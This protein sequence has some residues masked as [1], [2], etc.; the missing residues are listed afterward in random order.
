MMDV[1]D[2]KWSPDSILYII[3][4]TEKIYIYNYLKN[5]KNYQI[6]ILFWF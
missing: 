1:K 5:I 6:K 4:N 3:N 2:R